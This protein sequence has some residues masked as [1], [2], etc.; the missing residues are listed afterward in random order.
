MH[1]LYRTFF[2]AIARDGAGLIEVQETVQD[3]LSSLETFG[4]PA[5]ARIEAARARKRAS[6]ALDQEWEQETLRNA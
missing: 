2:A 6:D 3:S 4:D 5:A 1:A